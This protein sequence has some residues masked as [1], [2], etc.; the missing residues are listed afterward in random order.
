MIRLLLR[1]TFLGAAIGWIVDRFLAS[2]A[3]GR[4][5]APIRSMIVIDAPIERVWDALA[6]V[7]GQLRWMQDMKAVRVLTR[8]QIGVGTRAEAQIRIF[9]IEV[10]DPIT[11]SAFEP[12]RRFA[13][14][15]EGRFS[16]EGTIELEPGADGSTTI[17][18]W[19]ETLVPPYLPHLGARLLAPI[20]GLIFQADLGRLRE[21]VE[22]APAGS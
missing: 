13:I 8:G 22:T 17:V 9:G 4:A 12:P 19:Y 16:G 20:L 18:R 21:L 1:A 3:G 5:P 6:D 15:H 7:E 11:I 14:R 10:L 2:R